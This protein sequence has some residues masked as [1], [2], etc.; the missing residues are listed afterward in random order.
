MGSD[1]ESAIFR[2]ERPAPHS[3]RHLAPRVFL[4]VK[5]D[6]EGNEWEHEFYGW[7]LEMMHDFSVLVLWDD[8]SIIPV[9]SERLVFF[10]PKGVKP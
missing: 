10:E 7:A 1:Y 8:G 4:D 2:I 5:T 3:V 6:E 9:Q